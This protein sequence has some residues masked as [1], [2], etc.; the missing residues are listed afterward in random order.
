MSYVKL[1][2][3]TLQ[4]SDV[5]TETVEH[6]ITKNKI[7]TMSFRG[8][9]ENEETLKIV[10]DL[11]SNSAFD[12]SYD[13]ENEPI[14]KRVKLDSKEDFIYHEMKESTQYS[15]AMTV[16]ETDK[17]IPED[18]DFLVGVCEGVIMNRLLIRSLIE[19]FIQKGLFT[20]E[21]FNAKT[22]MIK[23]R[24]YEALKKYLFYGIPEKDS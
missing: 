19:T 15:F 8:I 9:I 18:W 21:E 1:E 7:L 14:Q 24:D 11:I 22:D 13:A 2:D 20:R 23:Q 16:T 17:D 3:T 12:F 10:L 6:P 5:I 4:V